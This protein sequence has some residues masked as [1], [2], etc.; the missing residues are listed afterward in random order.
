MATYEELMQSA[1]QIRTNELPESNTHQLVGQHLKNQVEHFNK[2]GNGI[3]SLIEANKKEVDGKLTELGEKIPNTNFITCSTLNSVAN[4]T[5]NILDFKLSNR[6]RL[7]VKMVNANAADNANLS[8]SSPQLDTKPLYYNGERASSKNSW[9]A[10][11]VLDI[12]YD[13][14]YFQATDFQGGSRT[15]SGSGG[16]M[17]LEWNTDVATTRKQVKQADRKEGLQISYKNADD[18][19]VNEQYIGND[20][21]DTEWV[22]DINW[23]EAIF[24]NRLYVLGETTT[25]QGI[26]F[27]SE[28]IGGL[29][30]TGDVQSNYNNFRYSDFLACIE[31]TIIASNSK[32]FYFC[33]YSNNSEESFL[34]SIKPNYQENEYAIPPGA[35]YFRISLNIPQNTYVTY[36]TKYEKVTFDEYLE[37]IKSSTES[38][39]KDVES[40][41]NAIDDKI[42]TL[43][44]KVIISSYEETIL[45]KDLRT[46]GGIE[47]GGKLNTTTWSS[48]RY[49]DYTPCQANTE[50][51]IL[52]PGMSGKLVLAY[53][54]DKSEDA[55]L[56]EE[57][58]Q[59]TDE[60]TYTIPLGARYFRT[61]FRNSGNGYVKY[62]KENT[63]KDVTLQNEKEIEQLK[64]A[65]S[66]IVPTEIN[67]HWCSLGTSITWY[68]DH[69]NGSTL[70]KGYQTRVM[71]VLNF[72]QLTNS[73]W[74][75]GTMANKS[76]SNGQGALAGNIVAADLYTIEYGIN[77]FASG[78]SLGT[79]E[80]FI[81]KTGNDTFYGAYRSTI[82]G[83][84]AKNRKATIVLC[85]PRKAY[86]TGGLP[87]HWYDEHNGQY[88]KDFA[89]AVIEIGKYMSLPV[90]DWF[91][92]SSANESTLESLSID[93]ALHPNDDGMELMALTLISELKKVI[94]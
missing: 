9:E 36:Y 7:L 85:T 48:W 2:E 80:D 94:R 18:E 5:V 24:S 25:L 50:L 82:D 71:E 13:G 55:F 69:T 74:S 10:G 76:G 22:K 78:L 37:N 63:I 19:W 30:Q 59:S 75:G 21:T 87:A 53:Y 11:A 66:T 44:D 34:S 73:G 38:N 57:K 39:L 61:C 51:K 70:T 60:I 91:N 86:G 43:N 23:S 31:G 56:S 32:D 72:K 93:T 16:N 33:F 77:D 84:Y 1:E 40:F 52:S 46:Y 89:D 62:I 68:N 29:T 27:P 90:C 83:I 45:E 4:K 28:N 15:G 12:Y 8:I 20:I 35:K 81:N 67:A 49:I 54:T 14:A 88:L 92:C 3:K 79:M 64:G 58:P 26:N 47:S 42:D 17:I 6:V 65:I 41:K